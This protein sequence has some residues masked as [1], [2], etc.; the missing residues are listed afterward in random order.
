[1]NKQINSLLDS[2]VVNCFSLLVSQAVNGLIDWFFKKALCSIPEG[3]QNFKI[4]KLCLEWPRNRVQNYERV[5]LASRAKAYLFIVWFINV[6]ICA[7]TH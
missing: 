5:I 6:F 1:M 7:F 4:Q 3:F 2:Y